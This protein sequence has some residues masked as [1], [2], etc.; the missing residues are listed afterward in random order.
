LTI[1]PPPARPAHQKD[2]KVRTRDAH[3]ALLE[4]TGSL[5]EQATAMA[6]PRESQE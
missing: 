3:G 1:Y 4:L 2:D 5:S 6:R